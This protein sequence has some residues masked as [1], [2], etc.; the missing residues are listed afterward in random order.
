MSVLAPRGARRG[1]EK[2]SVKGVRSP[3]GAT[4]RV[5]Q[6]RA[7]GLPALVTLEGEGPQER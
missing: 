3:G 2:E 4:N 5:R 6:T 1:W 7:S